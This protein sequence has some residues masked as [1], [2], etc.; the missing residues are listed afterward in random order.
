MCDGFGKKFIGV[1]YD[2]SVFFLC[3]I[4][5]LKNKGTRMFDRFSSPSTEPL[6]AQA[7]L[8]QEYT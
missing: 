5:G 4:V 1:Q 2:A 7:L 6:D 8:I 3:G